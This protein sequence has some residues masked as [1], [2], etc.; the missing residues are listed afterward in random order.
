MEQNRW[1]SHL[2]NFLPPSP[3]S[4][5]FV[6][7]II[8]KGEQLP[9]LLLPT[10]TKR[11]SE[12]YFWKEASKWRKKDAAEWMRK[13]CRQLSTPTALSN[14]F[15]WCHHQQ[16]GTTPLLLLL[17]IAERMGGLYYWEGSSEKRKNRHNANNHVACG[18][19]NPEDCVRHGAAAILFS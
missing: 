19:S 14:M 17:T 16:R 11:M 2:A 15:C 3:L 4:L 18:D 10:M 8:D 13:S 9:L 5:L 1:G 7:V 12:L 6:D